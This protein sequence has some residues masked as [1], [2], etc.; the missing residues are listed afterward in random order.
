MREP[1]TFTSI[2]AFCQIKFLRLSISISIIGILTLTSCKNKSTEDPEP[3][4]VSKAANTYKSD[5]AIKWMD[6]QLKL[7]RTTPGYA[8]PVAAR[9]LAYSGLTL[10]ES[11]VGGIKDN[12]SLV[13]QI[14]GLNKLPEIDKT[15]EYNWGLSANSALAAIIK[16]LF[17]ST[18][19]ANKKSIDSMRV[20]LETELKK[21]VSQEVLDR[22]TRLGADIALAIFEYSKKDGGHEAYNNNFPSDYVMPKGVGLWAPTGTQKIPLLPNWGKV[23]TFVALNATTD[24]KPPIPFSY[25]VNSEFFKQAKAVYDAKAALTAEQRAIAS[26]WADAGGTVTPPGHLM[27][28]ANIV[29]KKEKITLD[30]VAETYA[31][32]GMALNDAFVVCWRCK[33]RYNLIRPVTYIRET[34]DPNWTPQIDT[35]PFPEYTSGHSSGAGAFGEV[36]TSIY[37]DNYSF[38]DNTHEGRLPNRVFKSFKEASDEAKNSRLYGGIHYPMANENGQENGEK[39]AKNILALKFKK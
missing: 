6:L 36:M 30:K 1:L 11:V 5:I 20:A 19:D 26:F 22:S 28:I 7:I 38:T 14:N 2:K 18:N 8:P 31:K 12:Q 37:G 13:G 3:D 39:I 27:N 9:S 15:K 34:I 4:A 10:Y 35:P 23:R 29:I 24:P 21:D 33:Y 17:A 16:N 25:N 32:L